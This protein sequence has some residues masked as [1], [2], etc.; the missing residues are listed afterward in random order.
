[1]IYQCWTVN[2]KTGGCGVCLT[3]RANGPENKYAHSLLPPVA[4]FTVT[5]CDCGQ[6]H[7]YTADDVEERDIESPS[8]RIAV[9]WLDGMN[10]A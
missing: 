8:P 4:S 10:G 6:P 3:I 2:C 1:M 7:E 5:C 9:F